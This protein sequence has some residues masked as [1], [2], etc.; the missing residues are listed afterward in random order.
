MNWWWLMPLGVA[1]GMVIASSFGRAAKRGDTHPDVPRAV[2]YA[3]AEKRREV[4]Q[5]RATASEW[6]A[7]CAAATARA[8]RAEAE[9]ATLRRCWDGAID[10]ITTADTKGKKPWTCCHDHSAPSRADRLVPVHMRHEHDAHS[11]G[12]VRDPQPGRHLD[13]DRPHL[14]ALPHL[15][16]GWDVR[17]WETRALCFRPSKKRGEYLVLIVKSPSGRQ[18]VELT[19][20]P[21]GRTF[22]V[23]VNGVLYEAVSR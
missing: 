11:D 5:H 17:A 21:T 4:A 19:E 22:Q 12:A 2:E 10:F 6:E 1:A 18:R 13:V 16:G 3:H 23:H 9:L 15:L 7:R 20:S 14:A 8:E